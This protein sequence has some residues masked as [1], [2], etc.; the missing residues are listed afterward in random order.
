MIDVGFEQKRL[1]A[2]PL[3]KEVEHYLKTRGYSYPT[4][5]PRVRTPEP[6]DVPGAIFNAT[7]VDRKI[8]ALSFLRHT[9]GKWA[10][11][12][13]IPTATQVAYILAPVFGWQV[14]NDDGRLVRIIR[15]AFFDQPRKSAK[16]T[17]SAAI[18]FLMAFADGEGGAE[19]LLAAAS[20]DQANQSFKPL[21]ALAKSSEV[22][23]AAGVKALRTEILREED[24]SIIKV[25]SSRGD[26][27]HGAN[28]HCGVVDELHVHKTPDLLEA[29]ES[30]TGAREQPLVIIITT[31][32]DGSTTSPYAQR[33]K[34]IEQIATGTFSAPAQYGVVFA[35]DDSDDP[36][37]E[38]T[39]A[40]ANPLYPVT[41]SPEF[42]RA[43]ADKARANPVALASFRRL[44]LGVREKLLK[45]FINITAWDA[46][47][48]PDELEDQ[49]GRIA[50]GGLDLGAVSDLTALTWL[51]I[52]PEREGYDVFCRFWLPEAALPAL[53]AATAKTASIW[54]K[55]GWITLTPG[56]VT[57]YDFIKQQ[58]REDML[59]FDVAAI[60]F[61]RWNS[62]QLV[63]DLLDEG[64]P[65]ERINQS[66][67]SLSAPTKEI[68]RLSRLGDFRHGGNP[69]LRWMADNLRPLT[70]A[71]G[72]IKPDKA[73]SLDKID[74]ISASVNAL[75]I[76][77]NSNP[78]SKSAYE[79]GHVETI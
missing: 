41:P 13:L 56:S 69:V 22:L 74:G 28:V 65:M 12:P 9:K 57:D 44:H 4:C 17:I 5:Q 79:S 62:S 26:L 16:T 6:V 60:G 36:F 2:A 45:A 29:V 52:N 59:L 43:A 39:W 34:L 50:Y 40:K 73:R 30:G 3:S 33:R 58:I 25:V 42:M 49:A 53:D 47:E 67:S 55:Q 20:R 72:N 18:S 8:Q 64:I 63:I 24:G 35:S 46:C 7:E 31:A 68:D 38:S 78:P 23:Q 15:E 51:V 32:D 19:V 21:A 27:V 11:Q 70:D 75:F 66:V 71:N 1:L 61:D 76:A 10:G 77:M 54:V 14:R 37:E 48:D